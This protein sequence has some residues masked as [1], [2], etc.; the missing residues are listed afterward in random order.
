MPVPF[1]QRAVVIIDTILLTCKERA[2]QDRAEFRNVLGI[3]FAMISDTIIE[4][5]HTELC[6]I[7]QHAAN[8]IY[9]PDSN[10][11]DAALENI[12]DER[13]RHKLREQ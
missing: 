11:A 8:V 4:E 6:W 5:N 9:G 10:I 7:V 13:M 3:V 2:F 1:E 12:N